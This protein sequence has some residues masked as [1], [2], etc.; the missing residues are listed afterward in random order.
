MEE[1]IKTVA[2]FMG[3][4]QDDKGFWGFKN[5]PERQRCHSD[6]IKDI[7]QYDRDWNLLM[8]VVE[9]IENLPSRTLQG[10]YYLGNE[11]KIYKAINTN[12]HYCEINL[13]KESGYRIVSIQFNKESKI[14]SVYD[15]CIEF[16]KWYN[17]NSE[18]LLN[19]LLTVNI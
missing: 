9:K 3:L 15:A 4:F 16:I 8:E 12:T 6:R 18:K 1:K 11:V 19:Q 17:L 2:I 7:Y 13:V 10:T 14:K 5:T